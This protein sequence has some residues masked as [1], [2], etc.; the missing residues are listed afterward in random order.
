MDEVDEVVA[1]T[2]EQHSQSI[3]VGT[4]NG[5]TEHW[6]LGTGPLNIEVGYGV[7][8][9]GLADQRT[10]PLNIEVGYGV[11]QFGLERSNRRSSIA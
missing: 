7:G 8:Q 3:T 1:W 4:G 11:G 2:D 9:F 10:G 6:E 5:A